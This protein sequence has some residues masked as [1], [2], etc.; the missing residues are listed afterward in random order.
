[1]KSILEITKLT[2]LSQKLKRDNKKVVLVGGCFDVLHPGHVNFL[3]KAKRV[4]DVLV[5]L[6]E[7]DQKIKKLKGDKRPVHNQAERAEVLSSI[8]FVD[9]IVLLPFMEKESEYDLVVKSISPDIIAATSGSADN[10][11]QRSAKAVG[12][13]LRYVTKMIGNYSTS[14]I[15]ER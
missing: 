11:H 13:K 14:K 2:R 12:A 10:H 7:S 8:K 3:E 15:L 9:Y 1:M 4:G 6:L 5:I